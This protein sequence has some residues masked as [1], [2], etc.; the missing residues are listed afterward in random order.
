MHLAT[1]EESKILA[2]RC[3]HASTLQLASIDCISLMAPVLFSSTS[4]LFP[5][6][7]SPP[8]SSYFF[9]TAKVVV[10][11]NAS[12]LSLLFLLFVSSFRFFLVVSFRLSNLFHFNF[13]LFP[14]L[15]LPLPL[16]HFYT[17][18]I[19]LYPWPLIQLGEEWKK[20]E[21]AIW[22]LY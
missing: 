10:T 16:Y 19:S 2:I 13:A 6:S 17:L 3:I 21:N 14:F 9:S 1:N 12:C 11:W 5:S 18:S 8:T 15:S 22:T 4:I 20:S 7:S